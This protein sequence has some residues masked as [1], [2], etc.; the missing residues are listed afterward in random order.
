MSKTATPKAGDEVYDIRGRAGSYVANSANGHVVEP[1]YEHEGDDEAYYGKPEV[2][3]EVFSSPPTERLHAGIADLEAKL[4]AARAELH[5]IQTQRREEDDAYAARLNERKR[6]KQLQTLDGFIAGKITHFFTVEGYGERM[7]IQTFDEFMVSKEDRYDRKLRL[8][9]LFGGSKGD[10]AWYVDRYSDGSG[11]SNGRCFPAMS[12]E[13]AVRHASEWIEGRYAEV[14]KNDHKHAALDLAKAADGFGLKVPDDIAKW[15]KQTADYIREKN[16]E[17]ARKQLAE[18][19][20]KLRAL[21][22]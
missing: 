21:E 18:A 11:G 6:F 22:G 4:N 8:L 12:Y 2:W 17:Y 1:I 13:D 3:N 9:S 15:A 19:Q 7:S 10:L 16:L 20:E 5:A 14:R